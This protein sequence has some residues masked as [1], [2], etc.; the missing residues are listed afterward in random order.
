MAGVTLRLSV[1]LIL[2][3]M[4]YL[5]LLQHL[6]PLKPKSR[7]S[8]QARREGNMYIARL[9]YKRE[10]EKKYPWVSCTDSKKGMFCTVC[11]KWGHPSAGSRGAWTTRGITDQK[12][13]TELLKSHAESSVT[14]MQLLLLVSSFRQREGRQFLNYTVQLL[15]KS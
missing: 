15:L 8:Q 6:V 7:S 14:R 3:L 13:A 12:H 1:L 10:W 2:Q 4:V 11:Q 5:R 9:S